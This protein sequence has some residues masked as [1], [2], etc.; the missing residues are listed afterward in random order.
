MDILGKTA[1]VLCCTALAAPGGA[2][3]AQTNSHTF[4]GAVGATV[5][6]PSRLQPVRDLRFGNMMS[7]PAAGTVVVASDGTVTTAAGMVGAD[8]VPQPVEGRGPA[9]F[10]IDGANSR[11]FI[12]QLPNRITLTS[13][14]SS[15]EART[16]TS[17]TRPGRN[18]IDASGRFTLDVGAT[19]QVN[20][21]QAAGS[22]A[23]T[24]EVSVIYQ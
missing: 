1:A 20:A 18:T 7:P 15:M 21:N 23:G 12:V 9:R 13:A 2:R 8:T 24:F 14:T 22:Y 19:L 10:L 17:N 11:F 4:S 5:V 3:A 6:E 16:F